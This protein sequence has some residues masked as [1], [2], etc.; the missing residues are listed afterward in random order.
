MVFLPIFRSRNFYLLAAMLF[1]F[2]CSPFIVETH[3]SHLLMSI[4]MASIIVICINIVAFNRLTVIAS[5]FLATLALVEY[6]AISL[7]GPSITLYIAYF[8]TNSIFL[9]FMTMCVIYAVAKHQEI[10]IDTLLGAICG[11]LLLGL[12]WSHIYLAMSCLDPNS[13]S[14]HIEPHAFRD[15]VQHFMYFSYITLTTVGYGDITPRT[16]IARAFSWLEAAIGQI[17]LTVWISQLVAMHIAQ[18]FRKNIT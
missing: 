18:R 14:Y 6:L 10:T 3:F 1:Y 17:Y 15:N 12:T 4:L 7:I 9:F 5:A 2:I 8:V 13:F 16:D 11:Y